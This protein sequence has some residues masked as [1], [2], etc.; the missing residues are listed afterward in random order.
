MVF[1]NTVIT[2]CIRTG[3]NIFFCVSE[4]LD[5]SFTVLQQT[6]PCRKFYIVTGAFAIFNETWFAMPHGKFADHTSEPWCDVWWNGAQVIKC[7]WQLPATFKVFYLIESIHNDY[8]RLSV[9]IRQHATAHLSC[10]INI[11]WHVG[12]LRSWE[13]VTI[14][15]MISLPSLSCKAESVQRLTALYESTQ[16]FICDK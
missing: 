9:W 8:H 16:Y 4:N 5:R 14:T 10:S 2:L 1:G 12:I 6:S 11:T 15:R 3:K 7:K 13:Q